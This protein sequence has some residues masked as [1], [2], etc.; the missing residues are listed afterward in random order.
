MFA[1]LA[2]KE[3]TSDDPSFTIRQIQELFNYSNEMPSVC[4][5]EC[6]PYLTQEELRSFCLQ[7]NIIFEACRPLCYGELLI[8]PV[9]MEIAVRLLKSPAQVLIRWSLQHGMGMLHFL[10]NI[11]SVHSKING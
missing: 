2:F 1:S 10:L 11:S 9:V 6:N 4:Q 7:N 8:H 3:Y 5:C